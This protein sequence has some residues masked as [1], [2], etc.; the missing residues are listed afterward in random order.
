[1]LGHLSINDFNPFADG[2]QDDTDAFDEALASLPSEGGTITFDAQVYKGSFKVTQNRRITLLGYGSTLIPLDNEPA[3][4]VNQGC[5]GHIKGAQIY[6]FNIEGDNGLVGIRVHNS[7]RVALQDIKIDNCYRGIQLISSDEL[8]TEGTRMLSVLMSHCDAGITFE[9]WG[10]GTGSFA[11]TVMYDVGIETC[12]TGVYIAPETT[13][14]RCLTNPLTVWLND[15][16]TGMYVDGL[17][18]GSSFTLN[19]ESFGT[20]LDVTGVHIGSS[21]LN[22]LDAE[23][24]INHVGPF[25]YKTFCAAGQSF[26][27]REGGNIFSTSNA[28]AWSLYKEGESTP[29]VRLA[30]SGVHMVGTFNKTH[31]VL[32]TYHLWVD[33]L[34]RLRIKSSTPNYDTDGKVVGT[35]V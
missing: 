7:D 27:Y 11:E 15:H 13:L 9:K 19:L 10:N 17:V 18:K 6:G 23:W 24:I 12:N 21:A 28:P 1:M 14:Y 35:Q 8:W 32:G 31:L 34:G 25:T 30:P 22:V 29:Y 26:S 5:G 2:I 16:Q 20:P 4:T 33:L 3:I